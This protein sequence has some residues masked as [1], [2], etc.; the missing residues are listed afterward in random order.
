MMNKKKA[1]P[2]QQTSHE[3]SGDQGPVKQKLCHIS[4]VARWNDT[5]FALVNWALIQAQYIQP[6]MFLFI[7]ELKLKLDDRERWCGL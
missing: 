1:T 4:P 6:W 2:E 5:D 7:N 3:S